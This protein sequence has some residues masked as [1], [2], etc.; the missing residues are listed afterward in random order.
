[1]FLPLYSPTER[2]DCLGN[3]KTS[4]CNHLK[5]S[6]KR[7]SEKFRQK[8]ESKYRKVIFEPTQPTKLGNIKLNQQ[9][10]ACGIYCEFCPVFALPQNRCFGCEWVNDQY[11]KYGDSH[12]GCS[13]WE[14]AKEKGSECCYQCKEFPCKTHYDPEKAVYTKQALDSW[15]KLRETGITFEKKET[16]PNP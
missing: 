5:L 9:V 13:F 14:C 6:E 11:R 12:R 10:G 3:V 2:N 4:G 1:M 16:Q 15:K 8:S 7:T